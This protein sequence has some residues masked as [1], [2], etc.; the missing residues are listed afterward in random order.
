MIAALQISL[1]GFTQGPNGEK[2][3]ADSWASALELISDVD[4]FVLGGHMYPGY[5]EY[6]ES[7]YANP[8]R[9]PPFQ[10][11]LPSKGEIAYAR[12][13]ATTP[14]IV[15]STTLKSVSWPTARIIRD[16]AELRA[17]KSQAGKSMYVVGGATL[18]ASLL[19]EELIDELRLIVHPIVL[20]KGQGLFGGVNKRLALDLV[21]AKPTGSGR[22]I[23][24]YRT[25]N[26]A[27]S[28]SAPDLIPPREGA[29][30]NL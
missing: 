5:G 21:D 6:W 2:D 10:D 15:L 18:V 30:S 25:A 23:L 1:D 7:I 11:E 16:V 14:H 17:L 8:D 20:G 28:E 3:W 27:R 26:V 12:F 19:N 13:A 4:T 22:V 24:T 29:A 9:V